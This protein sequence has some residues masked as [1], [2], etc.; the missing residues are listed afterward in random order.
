[1]PTE[2]P[3]RSQYSD[4]TRERCN[5]NSDSH[6]KAPIMQVPAPSNGIGSF[7]RWN[8][9]IAIKWAVL[10]LI[11]S[12]GSVYLVE[13]LQTSFRA[14]SNKMSK[15]PDNEATSKNRMTFPLPKGQ[16][17]WPVQQTPVG[18]HYIQQF[19]QKSSHYVGK[20]LSDELESWLAENE[21]KGYGG[22]FQEIG[23]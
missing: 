10:A 2:E 3:V 15:N 9:L 8:Y 5:T 20:E 4:R 22:F 11:L 21:L 17:L 13:L 23:K 18:M 12:L 7:L 1:M 6:P 16:I 19:L 14:F